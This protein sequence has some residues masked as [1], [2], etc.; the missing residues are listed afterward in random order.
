M[1]NRAGLLAIPVL[2]LVALFC[3]SVVWVI[4]VSLSSANPRFLYGLPATVTNYFSIFSTPFAYRSVVRS[5]YLGVISTAICI[6]I[7]F[8]IASHISK[9]ERRKDL[10]VSII[11]SVYMVSFIVKIF[12]LSIILAPAGPLNELLLASGLTKN[13]VIFMGTELAVVIGLVYTALPITILVL[14]SQFEQIPEHYNDAAACFGA[15]RWQR[16]R[17]VHLPLSMPGIMTCIVFTLPPSIAAF[18]VPML[19]GRG[20]VNMISTQIYQSSSGI[21]G[22]NW[23]L[24]ASL[25]ILLLF[26]SGGI[27]L[28]IQYW[29]ARR[30]VV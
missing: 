25:S 12:A 5:I 26:I 10:I 11:L 20:R 3:V 2:P 13:P 16:L 24:A 14:L 7:G 18:E 1:K 9:N 28:A 27:I 15:N 17:Y 29:M 30:N 8:L 19:L 6:A 22:A 4:F 23:P 21:S